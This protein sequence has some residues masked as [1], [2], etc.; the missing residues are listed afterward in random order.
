MCQQ[1]IR[2]LEDR[3][4]QLCKLKKRNEAIVKAKKLFHLA[5]SFVSTYTP[6]RQK[7]PIAALF[8]AILGCPR[9]GVAN[10]LSSMHTR[11]R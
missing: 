9:D 10:L 3:V 1:K 7:R 8:K 4:E 6:T 2:I 5:T 11:R